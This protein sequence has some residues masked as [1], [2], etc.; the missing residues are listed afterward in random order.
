[1][2]RYTCY[3]VV[4][5]KVLYKKREGNALLQSIEYSEVKLRHRKRA[6]VPQSVIVSIYKKITAKVVTVK[7][8]VWRMTPF[9]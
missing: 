4:Y 8:K 6:A 7:L 2:R 5:V 9:M 1:M 3:T